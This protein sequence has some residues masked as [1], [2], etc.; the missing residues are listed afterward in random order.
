MYIPIC[1]KD[2][3]YVGKELVV[4][5]YNLS[6]YNQLSDDGRFLTKGDEKIEVWGEVKEMYKTH[7][8][9]RTKYVKLVKNNITHPVYEERNTSINYFGSGGKV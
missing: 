1:K 3:L 8:L 5:V 4:D 9:A 2:E 6:N 7:C